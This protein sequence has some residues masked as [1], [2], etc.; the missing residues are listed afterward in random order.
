MLQGIHSRKRLGRRIPTLFG[1]TACPETK[2]QGSEQRAR[3]SIDVVE[4]CKFQGKASQIPIEKTKATHIQPTLLDANRSVVYQQW[5]E[6]SSRSC[7]VMLAHK[8]LIELVAG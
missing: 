2:V 7:R 1:F 5:R 4:S 8:Y 6:V 3:S